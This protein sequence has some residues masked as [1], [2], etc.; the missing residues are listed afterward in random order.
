MDTIF[1]LASAQ[2][3]AGVAVIRISGPGAQDAARHLT[4]AAAPHRTTALRRLTDAAGVHLDTGVV[5]GFA[6]GQSF[7]GEETVEFQV[8]GSV[9]ITSAILRELGTLP[10]LRLAEPGEF[11][12][13][14]LENERLDLTQVEGLADLIEAETEAQ[15]RQSLKLLD[16]GLSAAAERWRAL[17][18]RALALIE[19]TIDFSDEELPEET[20]REALGPLE[21]LRAALEAEVRGAAISER[22]REGFEVALVG[23]PNVGK[24][25]L[26]NCLAGREAAITSDIAGTTRD[27][28]E[29]RMDL[30]GIPVTLLD[31]AGLRPT[32][33]Q[34]ERL[35]ID[36]TVSRSEASDI[37][38]IL[39]DPEEP[40]PPLA[41]REGDIVL[42]GKGDLPGMPEPSVSGKTGAGVDQL[43]E[44]LGRT[45]SDRVAQSGTAIRQRQRLA[46]EEAVAYVSAAILEVES[47]PAR[48]ELAA[49]HLYRALHALDAL[50]GRVDVERVLDEIFASFCLGK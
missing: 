35:G 22:V 20:F 14:A 17:I 28:I 33:D 37:R 50:I 42:H 16:G 31:T 3:R 43:V 32:E 38:V 10:G 21:E 1:A 9:A 12:R 48:A 18:I 5:I 45:L 8:H 46:I 26:L 47:G 15:R 44:A 30:M 41:P 4:G 49:E 29:V 11:T 24:S 25:T 19:A 7:T 34:I 2:G 27:V 40:A 23:R 13:R 39:L 36:R 6:E